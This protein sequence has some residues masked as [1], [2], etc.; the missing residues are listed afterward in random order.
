M[1]V[2]NGFLVFQSD[3]T[4]INTIFKDLAVLVHEQG[5]MIGKFSHSICYSGHTEV[6]LFQKELKW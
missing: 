2:L 1:Y 5:D 6:F 3:I 4:D